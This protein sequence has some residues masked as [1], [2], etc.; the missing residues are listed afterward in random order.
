[1]SFNIAASVVDLPMKLV[2]RFSLKLP[3]QLNKSNHLIYSS[4]TL[5]DYSITT[6]G[7]LS[8][9][10]SPRLMNAGMMLNGNFVTVKTSE[11]HKTENGLSLSDILEEQVPEKYFLTQD[12]TD[13]LLAQMK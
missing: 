12:K 6:K 3:E 5:K 8:E 9:P 10:S 13:K 1:M 2:E 4:K 11:Y 7:E